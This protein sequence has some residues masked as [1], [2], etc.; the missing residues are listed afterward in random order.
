MACMKP[1]LGTFIAMVVLCLQPCVAHAQDAVLDFSCVARKVDQK[2]STTTPKPS[3]NGGTGATFSYTNEDWQYVV[4]LKNKDA[5]KELT[6]LVVKY[7]IF[8]KQE[9]LGSLAGARLERQ[10]GSARIDTIKGNDKV[11]FSTVAVK[12]QK[13]SLG[14]GYSYDNGAKS[15]ANANLAGLWIRVYQNGNLIAEMSRPSNLPSKEKWGE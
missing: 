14:A 9:Q 15:D 13:A 4:T 11:E 8:F 12:L 1:T 7:I 5:F 6:N 2:T 3:N 10:T